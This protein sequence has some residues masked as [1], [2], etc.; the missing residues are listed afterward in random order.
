VLSFEG[1]YKHQLGPLE[2][3][4]N[5]GINV[6][7]D[8]EGNFL[9]AQA[10]YFIND[11]MRATARINLNSSVADYNYR[12]YQSNYLNYNWQNS[13]KNQQAQ[14]L[15]FEFHS[16]KYGTLSLDYST[17]NN[18]LYF[19]NKEQQGVKPYQHDGTVNYIRAKYVKELKFKNFA[20][21][22]TI[23]YQK[24]LDGDQVL[25]VPQLN[26]RNTF[27]YANEFFDKALYLQTGVTLSYFSN[28]SM[29]AYD[30]VL[31]E[32]YVQNKQTLGDF[33][34]LDFFINAKIQ[35]TRLFLK[36]EHFNSAMTGYNFYSAPNYP[37]RD[38]IVRF[39]IVWNFFL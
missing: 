2:L 5:L 32:F 27:Y 21:N 10:N 22:N 1:G 20:L 39:G 35:Q 37:Y 9:D 16:N 29:N 31:S 25:N 8:L 13:F 4:A 11:D 24:V 33:P 7:G 26:T 15:A 28:F 17:I 23:M 38:F 19:E 14:L 6:S 36:A 34:R 12:L 30:P 18:Y 3:N